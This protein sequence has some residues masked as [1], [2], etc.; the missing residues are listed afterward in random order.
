MVGFLGRFDEPRK[1]MATLLEALVPL[2]ERQDVRLLVVGRG[3][4]AELRHRLPG[5]LADRVDVLGA[6][7]ERTKAR[8]LGAM[9]VLATP[10]TGGESFG[11][12]LAEGMAAGTPVVASDLEA[13]RRVL[14]DPDTGTVAGLLLPPE[15]AAAWS[16]GLGAL[17]ADP[18]RRAALTRA[19]RSRVTVFDWSSVAAAVLRVY[20]VAVAADPRQVVARADDAVDAPGVDGHL[21]SDRGRV[22][23]RH[24]T[25]PADAAPGR[26]P[27]SS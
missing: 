18:A 12:V 11:I 10:N 22:G 1:G 3:D 27:S 16:R 17:L 4:V 25:R 19:G 7:D 9:D 2:A 6:V 23:A 13:F 26:L 21:G 8:A 20:E 24:R 15:D 14:T 5:V